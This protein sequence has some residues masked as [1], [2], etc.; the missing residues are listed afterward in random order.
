[1]RRLDL[2]GGVAVVTGAA[3]GIGRGLAHVLAA[4]GARLVLVDRDEAGLAAVAAELPG[5]VATHV[6]DLA[7]AAAVAEVAAAVRAAEPRIRLLVNNAGVAL[8]GRF[9]QVTPEEFGWVMD[10]NFRAPVLLCHALLPAL[11][12]GGHI[13]NVSSIFGIAAVPGN[14]AYVASKFAVRGF[15]EALRQELAPAGLGVTVV[16]PGGVRTAIAGSARRGSGVGEAEH[17]S[18][19][20]A[21]HRLLRIDPA[22]AAELIVRGAERRR[23]RVLIGWSARLPDAL[24]RA[25]PGGYGRLVGAAVQRTGRRSGA[26][27]MPPRSR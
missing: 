16:H 20:G 25:L 21:V 15:S 19:T 4:R 9:D 27:A 17:T 1:M 6:A 22:R 26:T 13:V 3:S 2:A 7:D 14:S 8:S 10:V 12:D 18:A 24:V 11:E 5:P 23:P